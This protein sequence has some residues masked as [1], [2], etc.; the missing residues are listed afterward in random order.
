MGKK[1]LVLAM[2][3]LLLISQAWVGGKEEVRRSDMIHVV[4]AT[5]ATMPPMEFV[6]ER[7]EIVGFDVDLM[8]A[9]SEASGF[10][11]EFRQ[12]PWD[13]IFAGLASG[14][15]DAIMSSVTITGERKST[16]DFSMPYLVMEQVLAVNRES[17]DAQELKDLSGQVVAALAGSASADELATMKDRYS[18]TVETYHD[19]LPLIE[20]LAAGRLA[21]IMI[22]AVQASLVEE[23]P[24]YAGKLHIVGEPLAEEHYGVAV[25]KGNRKVLDAIN[26][27]LD[28]VLSTETYEQIVDRWF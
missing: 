4:I 26:T 14:Q 23:D 10:T 7:G 3:M 12:I 20:D 2:L 1:I 19:S 15:Y 5:D 6:D 18:L 25:K 27:G 22:D 21:A 13:F 24:R 17:S 9:A 11:F 16:M 8:N 28:S